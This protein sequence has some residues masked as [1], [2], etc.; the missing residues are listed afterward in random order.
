[1][2]RLIR[3]DVRAQA[4]PQTLMRLVGYVAQ[5]GLVP[6]RVSAR[7]VAGLMVVVIEQAGLGDH[8]AGIIAEK[9]RA[10]VLV[11]TVQLSRGR[12]PLF[13]LGGQIS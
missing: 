5:L 6:K 1:V 11:Q 8:Q 2:T 7:E 3:F 10:S 4:E 13:P 12:R 9:M